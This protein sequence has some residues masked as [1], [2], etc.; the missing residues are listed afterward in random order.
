M[1]EDKKTVF[2]RLDPNHE[3]VEMLLSEIW[4]DEIV[5]LSHEDKD[6]N[7]QLR[8]DSINVYSKMGSMLQISLE[9][10]KICCKIHYKYLIAE[11]KS[12]YV[13]IFPDQKRLKAS[14]NECPNIQD[15]L[16]D[17]K[18]VKQNIAVYAG[19][20]K[21]IQSRLVEKNKET[22]VDVEVA[23]SGKNNSDN[24]EVESTRIDIVN[25]DKNIEKLCF[26]RTET[27][28]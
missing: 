7:I 10:R 25:Y 17:I 24:D 18:T 6:I 27:D 16:K 2:T 22:I 15:I 3:L 5:K 14:D 12:L 19:E 28:L 26:C 4:W 23:F 1:K 13:K 8:P 11:R 20:E 9:G 21:A